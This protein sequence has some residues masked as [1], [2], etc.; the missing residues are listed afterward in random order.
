MSKFIEIQNAI[1]SL[2]PGEYQRLCSA[3]IIKK[4]DFKNMH[5][6]GSKEGTNKTTKGI[7]DSYVIDETQRYTL[8]MYGTVGKASIEK[9]V[10]DIKE[11]SDSKKTGIT[12]NKIKEIIC[13]HTNTNIKPGDYD[14]LINLIPNI[15]VTLIDIDSMAHDIDENYHSIANDYLNISIDTNQIS[16]IKTFIERYDKFSINSPLELDFV[17]RK[18]K[19]LIYKN[20]IDS[21]MTI[22]S[23]KPGNGKTK[24]SLE[25]LKELERKENYTPLCIRINGLN[26]Y[27]DIKTS[28]KSDKKYIIFIDDINNLNGLNSI[29]DLIITNKN[30]KIK[31]VATVRDYLLDDVLD[32]L[33]ACIEPNI[34]LLNKVE[35][36]ELIDILEK[37][38]N[39]KNKDWQKKIL[40]I[41]NGN[42]RLAIMSF[43]AVRDGKIESLN[44][45]YD[46]FKNYYDSIFKEKNISP[47]EIDILFYISLLSP[48]STSNEIVK[49]IL[50]DLQI[51]NVNE[52]KK[53]RDME[54]IDYFNEDA[55]K[56][57]D[58]NFSN[59]LLCKYL[60]VDKTITISDLLKKLYS[61]FINKFINAINMIN[62]Q[63]YNE[64]TL[65]YITAEINKVWNE[66]AYNN[67]WKFVECFHSVNP[68]KSLLKIKNKIDSY[69]KEELPGEIKYNSNVYLNDSLLSLISDFKDTDYL[70]LSFE[71][72]LS[73]LEKRPGLYNEICKSIKDYWLV[74][75]SHP[76]FA[77]EIEII[78]ILY[79]KF[80]EEA[81]IKMKDIYQILLEQ[82]LLYCLELEFHISEQ[83]KNAR[84]INLIT[85]KLQE[86]ENVF[87][88]RKKLFD[89]VFQLC[90]ENEFNYNI[91]LNE[92]VW[93]YDTDQKEILKNDI[94]YLDENYF[95][96][97]ENISIIQ[98]KILYLLK[99]KCEKLGIEVPSSL[100]KYEECPEFLII[101]MFEKYDYGKSNKEL[102]QYLE[103]KN[104]ES[105]IKIFQTL[106][107]VEKQNIKVDNW[108][109]QSSLDIL[110]KYL[111]DK[112]DSLFKD[113]FNS[114]LYENCPFVNGLFFIR[115]IL[116][117]DL[118]DAIIDNIIK[119]NTEKK[120]YLLT[121]ILN[122]YCNE[123]YI[124]IV[125]DF[126]KKQN[127]DNKYTLSIDSI[128]EYSKYN[129]ELLEN[130]TKEILDQD[131]FGLYSGYTNSF[132][133]EEYIEIIY[134]AFANKELLEELYLKSVECHGDYE[135]NLGYLLC[136]NNYDLLNKILEKDRYDR[137]GK[138]KNI[139]KKIWTHPNHSEIIS[140]NYNKI[141]D[142]SLGYLRL[143]SLFESDT[144]KNIKNNQ[145]EWFKN[146]ILEFKDDKEK[147]Y[148]LFYVIGEKENSLK[149]ELI[150]FLLD[151]TDNIEIFKNVSLFSHSESWSGSRI[152][153]IER[154]IEFIQLLLNKIKEKDNLL[155]IEH[156]NYLNERI[157]NYKQEIKRTQI[158]EYIDDFLN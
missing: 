53:L 56:I 127:T 39:V 78:N 16:D 25:I 122:N 13:F 98:G 102:I 80:K 66:E 132:A 58:Q 29:I 134:N 38:Y 28:I 100:K 151:N 155:Y 45:V 37:N 87:L 63:F 138:I 93:F 30:E 135:G 130:Y 31:I 2:G 43:I 32:K 27:D 51:Y 12:K 52:F 103:N 105:Y 67:D 114:Y 113:I 156:I 24:I 59:Y 131:E 126:I 120:Y 60:I 154:K 65:K 147:I 68:S 54:L 11:A 90:S 5:D 75:Q 109:V 118:L 123:K 88:F 8:L 61:S 101:N 84:T 35:D 73:Y 3:Y 153:N 96:H 145:I 95:I 15:I 47:H 23:G 62:E 129:K 136:I 143:H 50:N 85:L 148:C 141:I 117:K 91:L 104:K 112:D 26:L 4:Y 9:L 76:N 70:K 72:L 99:L 110:F 150:L 157:E 79:S 20:I 7:P 77:L 81:N 140:Y 34:Y 69:T 111:I 89:V 1:L 115:D 149:E 21:K 44:S 83:G 106:S 57:C 42:P 97:W 74:K 94:Q 36:S 18:D 121:C 82:S 128:I 144:D 158:E 17:Y 142:S 152:P 71:L 6:I 48:I 55:L 137:T 40:K 46:V 125:K 22:I 146:K 92:Q 139:I 49:K 64:E 124:F 116:D 119:S 41:S 33:N 19:D 86:S 107:K 10:K 133:D 14:M 108:K